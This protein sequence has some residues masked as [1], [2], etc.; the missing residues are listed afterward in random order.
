ML[1]FFIVLQNVCS[2]IR[3]KSNS[4][5]YGNN[6]LIRANLQYGMIW[7]QEVKRVEG[8]VHREIAVRV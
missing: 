8:K 2:A 6:L 7:S 5:L 3:K 4:Q 1:N